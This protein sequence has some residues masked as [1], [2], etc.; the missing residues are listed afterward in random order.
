MPAKALESMDDFTKH[1]GSSSGGSGV[2]SWRDDD[3]GQVDVVLHTK[4]PIYALWSSGWYAIVKDREDPEKDKFIYTRFNSMEDEKILRNQRFR[5]R[6]DKEAEQ[7]RHRY[8]WHLRGTEPPAYI[9]SRQYPPVICPLSLLIEWV[10]EQCETSEE[11]GITDK[12]FEY[13]DG[14]EGVVIHAGCFC[15]IIGGKEDDF[16]KEEQK[17]IREAKIKIGEAY[18][19]SGFPR[20]QYV[21]CAVDYENPDTGVQVLIE[22]QSLGDKLK[23]QIKDRK[24]DLGPEEGDPKKKPVVFRFTYDADKDFAAKYDVKVRTKADLT[25][26]LLEVISGPWPED[27]V[28]RIVDDSNL[29]LFRRSLE[30][31][32]CHK[33]LTPP[34][35]AIFKAAEEYAKGTPAMEDPEQQGSK[36]GA[37]DK[38][39]DGSDDQPSS[40]DQGSGSSDSGDDDE[41]ACDHCGKG[42]AADVNTCP[43]C[44]ATYDEDGKM[45]PP[46]PKA[47]EKKPRSR[48]EA[49]AGK[50]STR[51]K[52]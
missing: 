11:M 27:K 26:E 10:R 36:P 23:K 48:S 42:M 41:I 3:Q 18:K 33:K 30:Q 1:S 44:G 17:A 50:A 47:E 31:H 43:H 39:G 35:E 8:P 15:G 37:S 4:A 51:S 49:A 52:S 13:D 9:G 46:P 2:L 5:A 38:D 20:M 7:Y 25:P 28:R 29:V 12:I 22:A 6:N 19:E 34:W 40:D 14:E 24:E 45:T 32:W 16:S 21:I